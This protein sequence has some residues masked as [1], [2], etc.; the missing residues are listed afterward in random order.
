MIQNLRKLNRF[1]TLTYKPRS[2]RKDW[3]KSWKTSSTKANKRPRK[4][5][6][7]I[8]LVSIWNKSILI[9][10]MESQMESWVSWMKIAYRISLLA[11]KISIPVYDRQSIWMI[12]QVRRAVFLNKMRVDFLTRNYIRYWSRLGT[13]SWKSSR[14]TNLWCSSKRPNILQCFLKLHHKMS[15]KMTRIL[16]RNLQ[17]NLKSAIRCWWQ[18]WNNYSQP[19]ELA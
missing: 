5:S 6:C 3:V 12:Q 9:K 4:I 10:K 13:K 15:T 14:K 11:G 7:K 19:P 2:I 18:E 8:L 17:K 16:L 1:K